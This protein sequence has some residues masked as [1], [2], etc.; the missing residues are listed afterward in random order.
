MGPTETIKE[1]LKEQRQVDDE[2]A[3]L[4]RRAG[5]MMSNIDSAVHIKSPEDDGYI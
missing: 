3:D 5:W 1:V 4:R 2:W